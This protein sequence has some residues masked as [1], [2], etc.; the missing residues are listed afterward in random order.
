[1]TSPEGPA[2]E[3]VTVERVSTAVQLAQAQALRVRVFV[4]EQGVPADQEVDA[5]DTDPTTTHLVLRDRDGAVVA[6]GRLLTDPTHPGEVHVG[7]VAVD[8]TWRGTGIGARLMRELEAVALAEHA[9]EGR[10]RVVL[11][12]QI[13]AAGFYERI[14][15]RV[16]GDV[17]LDAGIEH[18]DAAKTLVDR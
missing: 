2:G 10:C 17:Y 14:G 3:R 1:M 15:Y 5:L 6:T 8:A 7:R 12:A 11:S 13:Q 9:D 4:D 18:R 16:E